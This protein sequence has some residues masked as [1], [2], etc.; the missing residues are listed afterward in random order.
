MTVTNGWGN[1][2]WKKAL[3]Q[4]ISMSCGVVIA[5]GPEL[6]SWSL[7]AAQFRHMVLSILGAFLFSEAMYWKNW[8]DNGNGTT[9]K[10][11]GNGTNP[12]A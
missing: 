8:C 3:K 9:N 12:P 4:G 10:G 5:Y 11:T 6:V 2:V 7:T 1:G